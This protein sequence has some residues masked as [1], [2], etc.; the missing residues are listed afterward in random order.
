MPHLTELAD[1]LPPEAGP[2]AG[3][4]VVSEVVPLDALE[5]RYLAWARARPGLDAAALAERLGVSPRTL[6]RKLQTPAG[7]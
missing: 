3:S 1:D 7:G 2:A 4:F 5:R 6:Y